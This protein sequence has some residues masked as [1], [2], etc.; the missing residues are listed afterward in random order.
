MVETAK[1]LAVLCQ[2]ETGSCRCREPACCFI[3]DR[4]FDVTLA[5]CV[6]HLVG[7]TQ[8]D[9][10]EELVADQDTMNRAHKE[11]REWERWRNDYEDENIV[12]RGEAAITA[13]ADALSC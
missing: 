3:I 12:Q 5:V 8:Q 4:R 11:A 6:N 7:L 1:R 9:G 2:A 10:V 13:S